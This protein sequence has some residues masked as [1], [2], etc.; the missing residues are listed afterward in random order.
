MLFMTILSASTAAVNQPPDI[1]RLL[2]NLLLQ[3]KRK[4]TK[5]QSY[6]SLRPQSCCR[7]N[8]RHLQIIIPKKISFDRFEKKM[9]ISTKSRAH[10]LKNREQGYQ[11]YIRC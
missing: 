8:L 5:A 6:E 1:P 9:K 7:I 4:T 11:V 3:D 2:S 10:R